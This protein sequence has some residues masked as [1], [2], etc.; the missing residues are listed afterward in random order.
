MLLSNNRYTFSK[1]HTHTFT[2]VL[3]VQSAPCSATLERQ[4]E[5]QTKQ[6]VRQALRTTELDNKV[7]STDHIIFEKPMFFFGV[8][9]YILIEFKAM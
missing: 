8:E 2:R 6:E 3:Q 7:Y 9:I 5:Q 1:S 4:K